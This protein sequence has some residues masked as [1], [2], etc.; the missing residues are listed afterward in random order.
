MRHKV[1][2]TTVTLQADFSCTGLVWIFRQGP[3]RVHRILPPALLT[4]SHEETFFSLTR[5]S[6][7]PGVRLE[8]LWGGQH[9]LPGA[10]SGKDVPIGGRLA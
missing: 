9:E 4:E 8:P 2:S 7:V 10:A 1:Q 6:R 3:A 5:V